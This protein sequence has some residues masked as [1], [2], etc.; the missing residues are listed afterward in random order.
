LAPFYAIMR[1]TRW[2]SLRLDN[3]AD[4][5]R[6]VFVY[7]DNMS[8]PVYNTK[9]EVLALEW[10]SGRILPEVSCVY[11]LVNRLDGKE[12]Y[13]GATV[14]LRYRIYQH[15]IYDEDLHMV[16]YYPVEDEEERCYTEYRFIQLF[17]PPLNRRAGKLVKGKIPSRVADDEYNRLFR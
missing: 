11:M 4:L 16:L 5:D 17:N 12:D 9:E 13:I 1:L 6:R 2:S 14:N 3:E 15:P 10:Q 7:G 8:Y